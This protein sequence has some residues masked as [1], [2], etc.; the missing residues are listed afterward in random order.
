VPT[1]SYKTLAIQRGDQAQTIWETMIACTDPQK[2]QDLIDDLYAYC[3][4]DTLAMV[5]IYRSLLAQG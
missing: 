1:L 3:R 5:E 4:L 2:Q